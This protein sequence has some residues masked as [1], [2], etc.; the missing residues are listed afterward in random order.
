MPA[1]ARM[2]QTPDLA[3]VCEPAPRASGPQKADRRDAGMRERVDAGMSK[4]HAGTRDT[5]VTG[6]R[7]E[8]M[9]QEGALP[10]LRA[11]EAPATAPR[12]RHELRARG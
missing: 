12:R 2:C 4:A 3:M 1:L 8:W 10:R 6:S 7:R 5:R 9:T 11:Q